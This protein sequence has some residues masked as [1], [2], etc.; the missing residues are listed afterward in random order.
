[1]V[2]PQ[3][4]STDPNCVPTRR[5]GTAAARTMCHA[6]R[7]MRQSASATLTLR[8]LGCS[9]LLGGAYMRSCVWTRRAGAWDA[10]Y[11]GSVD[12]KHGSRNKKHVFLKIVENVIWFVLINK[13]VF[14]TLGGRKL[15]AE[16]YS[17]MHGLWRSGS[18]WVGGAEG[19]CKSCHYTFSDQAWARPALLR[20]W[21]NF[22]APS[23]T[24]M[25]HSAC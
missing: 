14:D 19:A 3:Y 24:R 9:L 11:A 17:R 1:M 25:S 15:Q 21:A 10:G 16:R 18:A 8:T 22:R 7:C 20:S 2:L 5:R 23:Q 12:T 4:S 13:L 6:R